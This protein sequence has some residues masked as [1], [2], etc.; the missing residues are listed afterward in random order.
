MGLMNKLTAAYIAGM[1]DSDGWIGINV[2]KTTNKSGNTYTY[3][4][5]SIKVQQV[6]PDIVYWLGN[7]FGG[8][9]YKRTYNRVSSGKRSD[10]WNDSVCWHMRHSKQIIPFL[11]KVKPY[12]KLKQEQAELVIE[13][14]ELVERRKQLHP[15]YCYKAFSK[16]DNYEFKKESIERAEQA[17]TE[18]EEIDKKLA[19]IQSKLKELN[20]RGRTLHAER[21]SDP[22][23]DKKVDATV[24]SLGKST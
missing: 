13:A 18:V 14:A 7:S 12:L 16:R 11:R 4:V 19:N 8:N 5:P 2:R 20:S 22:T 23:A 17:R 15:Y 21:L 24:Q 3:Y 6:K 1:L 10:N 9:I